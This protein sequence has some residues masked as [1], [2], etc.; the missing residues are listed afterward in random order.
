MMTPKLFKDVSASTV[1]VLINQLLAAI[2]F[3]L[4][5]FYLPKESYG[6]L[7]WSFAVFAFAN[8]LL[9]LRLEQVV[10]RK[11]ASGLDG[12]AVMNVFMFHVLLTGISFYILL[13]LLNVAFPGF[14]AVHDLL[15]V[16]GI[17]QLF[18]FF[19]SPFKQV[20]NGKERFDYLAA[21]SSIN[22]L[23]RVTLLLLLI[24]FSQL[25]IEKVLLVF[26]IGSV[27]EFLFCF[28]LA[29]V[30]M[31][32]PLKR[33]RIKDYIKLLKESLP[34]IGAAILM[35]GIT[36]LD[37]I[38]LGIF[39]TAIVTAEYSFAYRVYELSPFPL[40]I[41]APVLL[42]RFSR[43]F[44]NNPQR[45][46]LERKEELGLLIRVEMIFATFIPLILNLAWSPL[47]DA[48]TGDK[49][50]QVNTWTFF[51]LSCCIPF[52]YIT[53]II[54]SAQFA[55]NKLKLILKITLVTFLVVL[56]GDI[57]FI[58]QYGALGAALV[59]LVAMMIEY[60]NFMRT[61][62]LSR[63][64][65]S[66][67]SLLTCMSAALAAG[68]SVLYFFDDTGW[69]IAAATIL[70]LM[71]LLGTRQLRLSDLQSVFQVVKLKR[72]QTPLLK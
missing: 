28:L 11:T 53:N 20:A 27:A 44:A 58:P 29:R 21:M 23:V 62:E 57:L 25:T 33:V 63:I 41:I 5:S 6:E 12:A 1:Q 15:L 9:S 10:V 68:F 64:R 69:Q 46:L 59:Y 3:L 30:K 35:A 51:I 37:W 31:N 7:N 48:L 22:N 40:L 24:F 13:L 50:G 52:Q 56:L 17:A 70:Y 71:I 18:S 38:F 36:R 60:I 65:E 61:S 42:S 26:I 2:V 66:W 14:F 49:Y 32:V 39:S 4:I 55:Q 45:S 54:W 16:V 67:Q 43:Y 47:M 8:N 72:K 34:Q 19:S